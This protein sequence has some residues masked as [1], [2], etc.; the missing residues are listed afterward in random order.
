MKNEIENM[1]KTEKISCNIFSDIEKRAPQLK[2][3]NY[4]FDDESGEDD[5]RCFSCAYFK[6][7]D[8]SNDNEIDF[9]ISFLNENFDGIEVF[10]NGYRG[11]HNVT[12]QDFFENY[13]D[14]LKEMEN[15]KKF[16]QQLS[17]C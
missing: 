12:N 16:L 8:E 9:H 1:T 5:G 6:E 11:Y 14:F 2:L 17:A 15:S 10:W 4:Q 7:R 3:I 13:D